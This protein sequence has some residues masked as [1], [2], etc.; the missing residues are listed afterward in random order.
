MI[1]LG[2]LIVYD[3]AYCATAYLGELLDIFNHIRSETSYSLG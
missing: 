2:C 1:T 3:T